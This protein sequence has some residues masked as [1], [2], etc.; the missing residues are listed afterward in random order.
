MQCLII[1]GVE[2][3]RKKNYRIESATQ[4]KYTTSTS[5]SK[6]RADSPHSGVPAQNIDCN[7]ELIPKE[8]FVINKLTV[9]NDVT[10][11]I[12]KARYP[13]IRQKNH[14]IIRKEKKE[15]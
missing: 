4:Y 2:L 1:K 15:S 6:Y 5:P 3:D 14:R 12:L 7:N 13:Y 9:L 10:L 8:R 11:N